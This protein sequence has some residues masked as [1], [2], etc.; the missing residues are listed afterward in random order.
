M[1]AAGLFS[2]PSSTPGG[3]SPP[4]AA[5]RTG[6]RRIAVWWVADAP[7][8]IRGVPHRH[9]VRAG[10]F[11]HRRVAPAMKRVLRDNGLSLV[12]GLLFLAALIGQAISG[13]ADFNNQQLASGGHTESFLQYLGSS[14]FAV[15]VAENWQ[16]EYLQFFLYILATVWLM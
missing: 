15:D 10:V 7:G 8:D 13:H 3:W 1:P 16:S 5:R 6:M 12:F 4:P 14:D 9:S 2:W 11:H